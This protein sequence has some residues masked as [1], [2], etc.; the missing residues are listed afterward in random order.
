MPSSHD[1]STTATPRRRALGSKAQPALRDNMHHDAV[2]ADGLP[3]AALPIEFSAPA[4]EVE[5]EV[6]SDQHSPLGEAQRSTG[7]VTPPLEVAQDLMSAPVAAC[8]VPITGAC[9]VAEVSR[10][11]FFDWRAAEAVADRRKCRFT[12][13][14]DVGGPGCLG[15][16][17]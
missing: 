8:D 14:E 17:L 10:Q 4:G 13:T 7:L 12:I 3:L 16:L 6:I 9:K 5:H 15:G 11:A 2:D 1:G